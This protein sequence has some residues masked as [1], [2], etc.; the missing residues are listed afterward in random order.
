MENFA[1]I[2][3][4]LVGISNPHRVQDLIPAGSRPRSRH[5]YTGPPGYPPWS[6]QNN[7]VT[8]LSFFKG[9]EF[10]RN[11]GGDYFEAQPSLFVNRVPDVTDFETEDC[12]QPIIGL[13]ILQCEGRGFDDVGPHHAKVIEHL[14]RIFRVT[15]VLN[16]VAQQVGGE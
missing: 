10:R 4:K 11:R 13:I 12:R 16:T 1:S 3:E 5:V 15:F 7:I 6:A 2:H 9:A 8:T 14:L